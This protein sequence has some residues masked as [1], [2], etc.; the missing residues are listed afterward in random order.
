MLSVE[1]GRTATVHPAQ[2][3]SLFTV[4]PQNLISSSCLILGW[5]FW[6]A[7]KKCCSEHKMTNLNSATAQPAAEAAETLLKTL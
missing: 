6:G 3:L 4:Q 5:A 1:P 7:D 2:Q